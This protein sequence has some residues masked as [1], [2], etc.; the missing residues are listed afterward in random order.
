MSQKACEGFC[1]VMAY[2]F[3]FEMPKNRTFLFPVLFLFENWSRDFY[4]KCP[5]FLCSKYFIISFG[6]ENRENETFKYFEHKNGAF[7]IKIT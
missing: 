5:T 2:A 1:H 6:S 4:S 3:V 7:R